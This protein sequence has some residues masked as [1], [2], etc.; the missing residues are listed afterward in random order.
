MYYERLDT[1]DEIYSAMDL[2]SHVFAIEFSFNFPVG[3]TSAFHREIT[4][5]DDFIAAYLNGE[6]VMYGACTED[7][8]EVIG[9]AALDRSGTRLNLL[10]V[11]AHSSRQG[12]GTN[13][14]NMVFAENPNMKTLSV[15]CPSVCREFFEAYGFVPSG[16]EV[17]HGR[18]KYTPMAFTRA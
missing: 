4:R 1:E 11:E 13:L 5:N 15:N 2:A 8:D 16:D 6:C 18:I 14:L 7:T 9:F 12:I 17:V 3:A 10:F